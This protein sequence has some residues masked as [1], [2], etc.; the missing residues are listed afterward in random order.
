[1][2]RYSVIASGKIRHIIETKCKNGKIKNILQVT[3]CFE[4]MISGFTKI[5]LTAGIKEFTTFLKRINN[6]LW[7]TIT[8]YLKNIIND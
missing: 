7:E 6:S 5:I 1:M 4:N 3:T 8:F 2:T